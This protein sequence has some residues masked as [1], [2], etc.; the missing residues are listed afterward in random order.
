MPG[1]DPQIMS[2]RLNVDPGA[3]PVKQK[4]RGMST[5]RQQVV[6]KEVE[7]LLTS[8]S[9]REIQYPDWLA[10]VILVRK[11]NSKR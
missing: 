1:I 9:I 6:Q 5:K 2:H 7:K 4:R 10:N 8:H 11:G 3:R